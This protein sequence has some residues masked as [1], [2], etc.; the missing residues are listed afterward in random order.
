[1]DRCPLCRHENQDGT[2]EC[3]A[4]GA[5]LES[6]EFVAESIGAPPTPPTPPRVR[7]IVTLPSKGGGGHGF[8]KFCLV[9][10]L[11]VSFTNCLLVPLA[12]ISWWVHSDDRTDEAVYMLAV[13]IVPLAFF[14]S[15]AQVAVFAHV[16]RFIDAQIEPEESLNG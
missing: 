8:A 7:A 9:V 16:L 2:K 1:M 14:L 4:C 10:G 13:I 6:D 5:P 11:V 12:A 3:T 15:V